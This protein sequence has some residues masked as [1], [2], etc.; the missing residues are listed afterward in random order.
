MLLIPP[1]NRLL[2]ALPPSGL[3]RLV[4][5]LR[6]VASS[7]RRSL[8]QPDVPIDTVY[9]PECG[10]V[11]MLAVLEDSDAA[12]VGLIGSEG[13]V[14]L[15]VALGADRDD[16]EAMV[17]SPGAAYSLPSKVLRPAIEEDPALRQ[18]LMRYV[19][20]LHAQVARTGACNGRHHTDQRLVR[21]LPMRMT[22]PMATSSP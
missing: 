3:E 11:S 15:P 9:F 20:A 13:L 2:A 18:V 10:W 7:M 22:A 8:H 1:A 19:L 6:P 4:P 16:L 5:A 21:W 12:E 17:Q 14:G